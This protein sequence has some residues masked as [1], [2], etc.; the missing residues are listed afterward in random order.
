MVW[1][2]LGREESAA[3]LEAA[4]AVA[5]AMAM[6]DD[7]DEA[8][9]PWDVEYRGRRLRLNTTGSVPNHIKQCT[10]ILGYITHS[11]LGQHYHCTV[12]PDLLA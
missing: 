1:A 5:M 3:Q 8:A 10:H 2:H 9:W 11:F 7:D 12:V 4:A 6:A